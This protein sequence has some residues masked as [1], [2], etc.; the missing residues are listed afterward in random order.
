MFC[1]YL[2]ERDIESAGSSKLMH[3]LSVFLEVM[4][5]ELL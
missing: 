4:S 2:F 3:E 5:Y 1:E